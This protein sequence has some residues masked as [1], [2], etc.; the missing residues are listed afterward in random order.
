MKKSLAKNAVFNI[1]YQSL[2]VLFPLISATYVSRILSPSGMGDVGYAQN[3]VSYFVMISMLGIPTYGTREIAKCGDDQVKL[4]KTFSEL[5][6]I[7]ALSTATCMAAYCC[8]VLFFPDEQH[9]LLLICGLELFFNFINVDW[10]YKGREDFVYIAVRSTAVKIV[11]ICCLFILVREQQDCNLYALIVC[12]ANGSNYIFNMLRLRRNV[13][14]VFRDL[15]LKKH[16]KP[17]MSLLICAV[18]SSLYSKI[19]VTMLGSMSTN[20]S[21]GLYSTAFRTI[22][23]AISI[24]AA[25]TSI[26][27]PR[28]SYYYE[29][30]RNRFEEYVTMGV[31]IVAFLSIPATI[32]ISM[33]SESLMTVLFGEA[34][35]E[36]HSVIQILSPLLIIRG[37]GD[38]LCYQV[39]VSIGKE[40]RF[41]VSYILAAVANIALNSLLIPNFSYEGA[42]IASVISELI[43]NVTLLRYSLQEVR[44]KLHLRFIMAIICSSVAMVVGV[45]AV[46]YFQQAEL[47]SLC[48][49]VALGGLIYVG[50]NIIMQND[51]MKM[52]LDKLRHK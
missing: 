24:V 19:D 47:L 5:F 49:S 32:G 37:V 22:N 46:Q 13:K 7:N 50:L 35:R 17:L 42:A 23:I 51:V 30:N 16:M 38:I 10:F 8:T 2:N 18:A 25:S 6:L 26:F 52:V 45:N 21:V 31:K 40:N 28:I 4:N 12:L 27:L 20:V 36:G 9:V 41:L 39:L 15:C 34:F 14:F 44:P 3:I 11:S 29:V 1:A 43:V 48:F 33:V